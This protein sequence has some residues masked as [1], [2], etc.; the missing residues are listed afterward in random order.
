MDKYAVIVAGGSGQRMGTALPK[1]FLLLKGEPV[2]HHTISAFLNAYDELHVILVLPQIHLEKGYE[3]I[4]RMGASQRVQI[5]KGGDSRFQSVKN[6]LQHITGSSVVFVHDGVRC[7]VS[8][9]LIRR[10]YEQA[11]EKGSA[12]PAVPATDSIR[13]ADGD[14][15]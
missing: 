5:V 8:P 13:I 15:A 3:I 6:G 7:T 1:Q 12:I 14:T 2:L 11:V 4:Q 9:S 10:C